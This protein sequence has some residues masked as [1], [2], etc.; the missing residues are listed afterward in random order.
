[1]GMISGTLDEIVR[2]E[3][4]DSAIPSMASAAAPQA[5]RAV[6]DG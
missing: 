3:N 2:N 4:P 6:T 1:M 5:G